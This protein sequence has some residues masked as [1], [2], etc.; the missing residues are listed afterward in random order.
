MKNLIGHLL[1]GKKKSKFLLKI[2]IGA[3]I[4]FLIC[5]FYQTKH[6]LAAGGELNVQTNKSNIN[7]GDNVTITWIEY[8]EPYTTP[9]GSGYYGGF[10][11]LVSLRIDDGNW[12]L[13]N[14]QTNR[15]YNYQ[16]NTSGIA[17]FRVEEYATWTTYDGPSG[18]TTD[19]G[20]ALIYQE[21][22]I[23]I[24]VINPYT[25]TLSEIQ[26]F[27]I[28]NIISSIFITGAIVYSLHLKENM[29]NKGEIKK[30]ILIDI[31]NISLSS[32]FTSLQIIQINENQN[33]G[34]NTID[35]NPLLYIFSYLMLF[36]A[37]LILILL[38]ISFV[39]SLQE[40]RKYLKNKIN[41]PIYNRKLNFKKVF[42]NE[43]R[44]NLIKTIL[45][46]PGIHF[47]ELLRKCQ[48]QRGQLQWHLKILDEFGIIK[49]KKI[50]Q[51]SSFF[52][53]F[54]NVESKKYNKIITKSNIR[55][56]LLD[57]IRKN[58]GITPTIIKNI[59][60]INL[61]TI[62]YHINKLKKNNFIRTEK[63]GREVFLFID[64]DIS[65][66]LEDYMT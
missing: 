22:S 65:I 57:I 64:E 53:R 63:K 24:E 35:N 13:L 21:N 42:E 54:N 19:Y 29:K 38:S 27:L 17:R 61:T 15:G 7:I 5:F 2:V 31:T 41:E 44:Q 6:I 45:Q 34:I 10:F 18:I 58:P 62:D 48:L 43:T 12:T 3:S 8:N 26:L 39:I 47:Q 55:V 33:I 28:I 50:G 9:Y 23:N 32:L 52:S 60:K 1:I 4:L 30:K 66:N 37:I 20:I 46:E 25:T 56:E 40:Y 14:N 11:Y 51:Y 59:K 16:I 49:K 36:I